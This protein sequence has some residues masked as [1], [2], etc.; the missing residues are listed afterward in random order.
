LKPAIGVNWG[1]TWASYAQ[2]KYLIK[3]YGSYVVSTS[4]FYAKDECIVH[5]LIMYWNKHEE[6][7]G[8]SLRYKF[9]EEILN[10]G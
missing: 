3:S 2:R 6:S 8:S 4:Q 5:E 1:W 9:V 10:A 7:D